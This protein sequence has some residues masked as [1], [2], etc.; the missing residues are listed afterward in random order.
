[1]CEKCEASNFH[2]RLCSQ[3]SGLHLEEGERKVIV[4][5]SQ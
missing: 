4:D 1:M 3:L 5:A 2:P